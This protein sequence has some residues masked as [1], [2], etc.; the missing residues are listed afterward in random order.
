MEDVELI[1]KIHA[2]YL[3]A[4]SSILQSDNVIRGT[5]HTISSLTEDI[6]AKYIADLTEVS[7]LIWIDPQITVPTLTNASGKRKLLFRPDLAIFNTKKNTI[8]MVFDIK[9]DLG[10][11]RNEFVTQVTASTNRLEKI[12][13]EKGF[14]NLNDKRVEFTFTESLR[15]NYIVVSPGN[16]SERK[17]AE[18]IKAIRNDNLANIFILVNKGHLNVPQYN[19]E[20]N[21][22]S[23]DF[24]LLKKEIREA[25]Q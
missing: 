10:Y 9:M 3:K 13:S 25:I 11:K 2:E 20:K 23:K 19:Y 15:W 14:C 1:K 4:K 6:V 8:E 21:I 7:R 24:A 18:T 22:N 16:I 17:F 12:K 5:A